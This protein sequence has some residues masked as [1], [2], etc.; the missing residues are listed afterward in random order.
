MA[1]FTDPLSAEVSEKP[2]EAQL[3]S[4]PFFQATRNESGISFWKRLSETHFPLLGDP[5]LSMASMFWEH[6]H[7]RDELLNNE[8]HQVRGGKQADR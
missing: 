2:P 5:A 7:Q 6:L 1:L 4:D 3:Q 8:T